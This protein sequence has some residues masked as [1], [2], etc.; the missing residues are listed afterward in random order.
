MTRPE[1]EQ[2]VATLGINPEVDDTDAD[3]HDLIRDHK[4]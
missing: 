3:L 2:L 4:D 1:L